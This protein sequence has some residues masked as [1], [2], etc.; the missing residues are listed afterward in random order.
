[1]PGP[2]IWRRLSRLFMSIGLVLSQI[3]APVSVLWLN[4]FVSWKWGHWLLFC[5]GATAWHLNC[6]LTQEALNKL[7]AWEDEDES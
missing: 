1:M 3:L 6:G 4:D 2:N 5:V 7:W